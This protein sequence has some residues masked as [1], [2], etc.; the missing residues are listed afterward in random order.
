M[1][2][3]IQYVTFGVADELFAAPV[4]RIRE[5]LDLRPISHLPRTPEAVLGI[6]D[7]RG[8]TVP[9]LDL[10]K[11]LRMPPAADSDNTRIVVLSIPRKGG[12]TLLALKTDRVFEVTPLD[13][14]KLEP[15]PEVGPGWSEEVIAGVGR[16]NGAFVTV[17][18]LERLF[19]EVD[20]TA[21][22]KA[23]AQTSEAA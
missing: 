16:R 10:R 11:T 7:L 17:L 1:S 13:E 19:A 12:E 18:D 20:L 4:E 9:V 21:V 22:A 15:P 23:A 5:I 2:H 6:I 14:G 3:L 8:A